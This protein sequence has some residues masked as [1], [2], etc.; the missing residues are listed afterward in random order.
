MELAYQLVDQSL[1]AFNQP[2]APTGGGTFVSPPGAPPSQGDAAALTQQLLTAQGALVAVQ[3][4]LF[5]QWLGYLVARINL[6]SAIGLM[7]LDERGIWIEDVTY[8]GG[9]TPA[10]GRAGPDC[11]LPLQ[12]PPSRPEEVGPPVRLLPPAGTPPTVE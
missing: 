2:A 7:P 4:D 11:P 10:I 12:H 1:Q 3:N 8:Y 9:A 5:N 6:Y